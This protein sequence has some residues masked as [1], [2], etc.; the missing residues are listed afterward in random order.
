MNQQLVTPE[1]PADAARDVPGTTPGKEAPHRFRVPPGIAIRLFILLLIGGLVAVLG[2]E[3]DWWNASA[4]YQTTDDAY[5]TSDLTPLAAKVPGYVRRVVVQDF[6]QVKAGDPLVEI[7]DDDYR[8][9][10]A[11]A[12]GNVAAAQA[13]IGTLEQQKLLQAALI[14][15][16]Q[17]SIQA[18]EADVTRYHL[19]TVRQQS[20][21]ATRIAGTRQLVEQAVDNEQRAAA[22]LQLNH[23]QLSQ[24]LQQLNVLA[25]QEKT[26]QATLTVQQAALDLARINLGYTRITAP[27]DGMVGQRQVQ[28]GQY[29]NVGTQVISI[30]PLPHVWVIANYKETQMSRIRVGQP[31]RVT[32]DTFQGVVLRGHVDGWSP[33]SGAQFS[34]LPPDNATGNFTKVVQRISV[35]IVLDP[36]PGVD[37]LLRPGMSAIPT[38]DTR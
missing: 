20:L 16:A 13:G 2:T 34:L 5:L 29:L 17:A 23:A 21:L 35:K 6:Q 33:A 10:V 12:E 37:G 32:I 18:S 27:V 36:N 7:V 11:L 31:A 25:S 30:V 26:A 3:W 24:Q 9:Q 28:A 1:L 22:T 38:I 14:A 19:E 15:Q 4:N 8:A